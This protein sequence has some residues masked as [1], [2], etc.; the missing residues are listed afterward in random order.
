MLLTLWTCASTEPATEVTGGG[1]DPTLNTMDRILA[2]G[3]SPRSGHL[4]QGHKACLAEVDPLRQ[5]SLVHRKTRTFK[6]RLGLDPRY[7]SHWS[8]WRGRL[9]QTMSCVNRLYRSTGIT[10]SI[11]KI[12]AWDPGADRH[13]LRALL[14]RLQ[15][16]FPPNKN[17]VVL[18][19][20]LWDERKVYKSAGGEIGLSQ[21]AA[22]VVPSWPRVEN[23]CVIL[24]HELGH[25]LGAKHVPGKHWIMGWAASPF[26]LPATDPIARVVATYRFHPRNISAINAH[27]RA[28][29]TRSGLVIPVACQQ[30]LERIDRCWSL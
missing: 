28:T 9:V 25:L 8:D 19:I 23:D 30:K 14:R 15:N 6:I 4:V 27:Q 13:N 17:S 26:H 21:R 16:D 3:R 18:G 2:R 7:L 5:C 22:C 10:W 12:Y 1:E 29:F 20:T 11:Q 24:A